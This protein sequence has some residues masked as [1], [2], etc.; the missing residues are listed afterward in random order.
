[1]P[2]LC[3][4]IWDLMAG[5]AAHAVPAL[6]PVCADLLQDHLYHVPHP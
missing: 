5:G 6:E 1:M 2:Q 3:A 4:C